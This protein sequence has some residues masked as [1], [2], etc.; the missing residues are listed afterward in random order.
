MTNTNDPFSFFDFTMDEAEEAL[1]VQAVNK[2]DRRICACGHAVSAHQNDVVVTCQTSKMY[3]PCKVIRP[4]VETQD[5]RL[6]IRKTTGAGANHALS[7]GIA[8]AIGRGHEVVWIVEQR[9]DR[10]KKEGPVSPVPV[11]HEGFARTEAT[12]YDALLCR[13]CRENV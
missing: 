8:S 10:C 7:L 1:A 9:C 12:G 11:T 6:F 3:C 13:S 2:R 5:C 4:V